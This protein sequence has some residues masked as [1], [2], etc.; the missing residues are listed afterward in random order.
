MAVGDAS[1]HEVLEWIR[2]VFSNLK[3]SGLGVLRG[4]RRKH[5]DWQ[6]VEW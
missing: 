5:L 4:F 2:R 3:R 6:I 1:A